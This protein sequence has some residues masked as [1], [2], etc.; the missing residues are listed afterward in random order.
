MKQRIQGVIIGVLV[1]SLLF[2]GVTVF[3]N[4]T[5]IIHATYGVSVVVN[6]V[7]QHFAEDSMPFVADGRTFL[8]VRGIADALGVDVT[9][10]PTT[11][12][13]HLDNPVNIDTSWTTPTQ[14]PAPTPT[15]TSPPVVVTPTYL[16]SDIM[17]IGHMPYGLN[18]YPASGS[19][20]M[21]NTTF[22]RGLTYRNPAISGSLTATATYDIA[23]R[24]FTSLTG[25]FGRTND[26][27]SG[28]RTLTITGND[29]VFIAGYEIS[30]TDA[31]INIDVEI[32]TGTN[33][34]VIRI[35]ESSG[36]GDAFFN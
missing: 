20:S 24:G 36:L 16:E 22:F 19:F 33:Q 26:H 29:G 4:V 25:T 6:G 8:P 18:G 34:V 30:S 12:T 27:W 23:G 15:Q 32:P 17:A 13:V 2:G 10:N 21:N 28:A 31:P 11:Q 14:T 1:T 7:Q 9:W 3:A 35:S 5:R